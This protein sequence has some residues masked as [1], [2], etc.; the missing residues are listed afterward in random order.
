[1]N[2]QTGRLVGDLPMDR[3]RY[4]LLVAGLTVLGAAISVVSGFGFWLAN[5]FR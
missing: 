4:W 5:F 3:K 2:G 1:M